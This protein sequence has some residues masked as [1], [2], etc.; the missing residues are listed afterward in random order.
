MAVI[1]QNLDSLLINLWGVYLN[2]E[3]FLSDFWIFGR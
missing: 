3:S 1:Y 2:M